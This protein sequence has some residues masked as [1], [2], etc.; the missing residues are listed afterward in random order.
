[1]TA[2]QGTPTGGLR[3]NAAAMARSNVWTEEQ[4]IADVEAAPPGP[5]VGAFF[6]FDGTVIDG[7]PLAAFARH[8]LRAPAVMPNAPG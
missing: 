6:D 1:M 7:D 5:R 3:E 2:D 8:H 4:L